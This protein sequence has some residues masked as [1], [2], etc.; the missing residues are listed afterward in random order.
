[1]S[2]RYCPRDPKWV[3]SLSGPLKDAVD[4]GDV[5]RPHASPVADEGY[6]LENLEDRFFY[7]V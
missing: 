3:H 5:R 7:S 1:M 2:C 4:F 6:P